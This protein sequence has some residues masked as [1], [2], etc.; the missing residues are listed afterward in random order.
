M[1]RVTKEV[2]LRLTRK[3]GNIDDIFVSVN[4]HKKE[5]DDIRYSEHIARNTD[6]ELGKMIVDVLRKNPNRLLIPQIL[7]CDDVDMGHAIER[8][9]MVQFLEPDIEIMDQDKEI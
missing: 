2:M 5:M 8:T 6:I 4:I 7:K 1:L 9:T 3:A